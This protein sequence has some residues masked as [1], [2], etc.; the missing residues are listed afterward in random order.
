MRFSA[1]PALANVAG[2]DTLSACESSDSSA[3][4][5]V[6]VPE[7]NNNDTTATATTTIEITT[8]NK[9]TEEVLAD[10]FTSPENFTKAEQDQ[11]TQ[12]QQTPELFTDH[13][14]ERPPDEMEINQ[15]L[16]RKPKARV[17]LRQK[18]GQPSKPR[19]SLKHKK[20]KGKL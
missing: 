9:E 1:T 16:K 2:A 20:R 18:C 3:D 12:E 7:G 6:E 10:L 11:L 17:D 4:T 19:R 14:D 8:A 13:D 5:L 15:N